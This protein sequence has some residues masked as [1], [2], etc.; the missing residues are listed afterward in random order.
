MII[1]KIKNNYFINFIL[2]LIYLTI[3]FLEFIKQNIKDYNNQ[4][5]ITIVT[6]YI[7]ISICGVIF[8]L[9][10]K[11]VFNILIKKIYTIFY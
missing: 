4:V 3:P 6:I 11:S 7:L 10:V 9:F 8:S 2:S 5:F 1:E